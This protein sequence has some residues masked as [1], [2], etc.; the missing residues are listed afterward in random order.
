M[1]CYYLNIHFQGQRVKSLHYAWSVLFPSYRNTMFH[2]YEFKFQ[3]VDLQPLYDNLSVTDMSR[4]SWYFAYQNVTACS[5]FHFIRPYKKFVVKIF[6][7]ERSVR[8][9]SKDVLTL[10]FSHKCHTA[11]IVTTTEFATC[12]CSKLDTSNFEQIRE[13]NVHLLHKYNRSGE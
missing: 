8:F 10:L 4:T 13:Y 6:F 3:P 5:V 11:V 2:F 12:V 7:Y 9:G 1:V